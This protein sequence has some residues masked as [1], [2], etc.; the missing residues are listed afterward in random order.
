MAI[1]LQQLLPAALQI[2][3]S[4]DGAIQKY[5]QDGRLQIASKRIP[6]NIVKQVR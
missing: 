6:E 4:A 2:Q 1:E 3:D 5:I